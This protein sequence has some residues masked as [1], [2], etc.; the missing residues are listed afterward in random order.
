MIDHDSTK[1]LIERVQQGDKEARNELFR[2][3]Q[4]PVLFLVRLN[5]GRRLRQKVESWD[6]VQETLIKSLNDLQSF[7]FE[8]DNAFKRYLTVKVQ[9]VIRDHADYW[10]AA[11]RDPA[12]ERPIT[13]K[14][15]DEGGATWEP[16]D[17]RQQRTASEQV[18]LD[19]DLD[20]LALAMDALSEAAPDAW[21]LIVAVKVLGKKHK[22]VA[23]SEGTTTDAVKMRLRRAMFKLAR[24]YRQISNQQVSQ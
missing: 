1:V 20:Q 11:K 19:E 13:T 21:E 6:L 3:Y 23:D 22:E 17:Y 24:L 4:L 18:E 15:D 8:K 16:P 9:Q 7:R 10:N 5:L 2:R 12:C 14:L